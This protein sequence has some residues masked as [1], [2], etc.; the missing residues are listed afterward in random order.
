M[1]R[2]FLLTAISIGQVL[3]TCA[4]SSAQE[5]DLLAPEPSVAY[6]A[7]ATATTSANQVAHGADH[8]W[9]WVNCGVA[10]QVAGSF[11][12][13]A[14][15]WKQPEGNQ[16]LAESSGPYQG[17]FYREGT[18]RKIGLSAGIAAVS[19]LVAW[20]FPKARKFVG[21]F[22][23]SIGAGFGAAAVSNVMNNPYYKP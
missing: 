22:N 7:P 9:L 4:V 13:W 2:L 12:D 3:T 10:T 20:K 1:K 21:I 18:A 19:Y 15:S 14:T 8:W 5:S 23:M 16:L 11:A 6:V 17:R